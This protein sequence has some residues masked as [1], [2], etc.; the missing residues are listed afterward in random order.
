MFNVEC[1]MLNVE[2]TGGASVPAAV[3]FNIEHST[4][5]IQHSLL[6]HPTAHAIAELPC[7]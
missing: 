7:R 5:N 4:F 1:S 3:P 2:W 6:T